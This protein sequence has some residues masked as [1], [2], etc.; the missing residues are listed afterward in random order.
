MSA[1]V[2]ADHAA[3]TVTR[4]SRTGFLVYLNSALIFWFSKKQNSCESSTFGS[5]FTAMKQCCEYL[6]GLRY[7]LRM[8]GIP[9]EGPA[10]ILGDNQSVLCNTSIPDSTL[11]KKSQS[12]AYH[13]IRE[14]V[15]RGE[16]LTAYIKSDDNDADLLTKKLPAGLKR[17]RFVSNILHHIY[18]S[19]EAAGMLV[20][21]VTQWAKS[22][23]RQL[24]L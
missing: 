9:C 12:I 2:D 19:A 17:R 20:C 1:K 7:K 18:R 13:M 24:T 11:S 8:M 15:A 6:R 14:G 10:Y 21:A 5:E 16:W 23:T 3:D 4:R 22:K